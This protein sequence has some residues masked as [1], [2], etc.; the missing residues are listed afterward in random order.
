MRRC[1]ARLTTPQLTDLLH[2]WLHPAARPP[3]PN[4]S[5]LPPLER[6]PG[7]EGDA[8]QHQALLPHPTGLA[9][10]GAGGA[11]ASVAATGTALALQQRQRWHGEAEEAVLREAT[12]QV[13]K[14]LRSQGAAH[15]APRR[16]LVPAQGWASAQRRH[17]QAGND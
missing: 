4:A 10:Q 6:L 13:V 9:P 1:A 14:K 7:D 2:A 17:H 12:F 8:A 3:A 15:G 5:L 11:D 16:S